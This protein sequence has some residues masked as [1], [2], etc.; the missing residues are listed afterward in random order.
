MPPRRQLP[1]TFSPAS[2]PS[3]GGQTGHRGQAGA[4]RAPVCHVGRC[5]RSHLGPG[6]RAGCGGRPCCQ[7]SMATTPRRLPSEG[8]AWPAALQGGPCTPGRPGSVRP[9]GCPGYR[10]AWVVQPR[11]MPSGL[12]SFP[13]GGNS[14]SPPPARPD[15]SGGRLWGLCPV[16]T[17]STPHLTWAR[18]A[19]CWS[20]LSTALWALVGPGLWAWPAGR[21]RYRAL[22]RSSSGGPG[23]RGAHELGFLPPRSPGPWPGWPSQQSGCLP[24]A[25][26]CCR[27]GVPQ[28]GWSTFP[29]GSSLGPARLLPLPQGQGCLCVVSR[30][31][32]A[33]GPTG[34]SYGLS[35]HPS[36]TGSSALPGQREGLGWWSDP[37]PCGPRRKQGSLT[38][39]WPVPGV[40][41]LSFGVYPPWGEDSPRGQQ[42][43]PAGLGISASRA[44]AGGHRQE[45]R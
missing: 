19:C 27:E 11:L 28:P 41:R 33:L 13:V 26:P 35:L 10:K 17:S 36:A 8:G 14:A 6:G 1:C 7:P 3:G 31:R 2:D 37:G 22:R 38:T 9:P 12:G 32:A 34:F 42:V 44:G 39:S 24:V 29:G 25:R 30:P 40:G 21:G 23:R 20:R 4:E 16:G 15:V 5:A 18:L 45:V 43:D